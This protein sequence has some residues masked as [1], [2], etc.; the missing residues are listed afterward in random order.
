MKA[1]YTPQELTNL[2]EPIHYQLILKGTQLKQL[3]FEEVR[4]KIFDRKSPIFGSYRKWAMK[5]EDK[6]TQYKERINSKGPVPDWYY[7]VRSHP[8]LY[9][10]THEKYHEV[11]TTSEYLTKLLMRAKMLSSAEQII[12]EE[13]DIKKVRKGKQLTS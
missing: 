1:V 6:F 13:E 3:C 4:K 8:E 7:E 9:A 10:D 12:L 5:L 11:F 2:L